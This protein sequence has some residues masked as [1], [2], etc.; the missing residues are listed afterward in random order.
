MKKPCA[1]SANARELLPSLYDNL[2]AAWLEPIHAEDC[3]APKRVRPVHILTKAEIAEATHRDIIIEERVGEPELIRAANGLPLQLRFAHADRE[4]A[5]ALIAE[6]V[7]DGG[8]AVG[9]ASSAKLMTFAERVAQTDASVL[10]QG[11]TGTG[12]EG[13]ARFIHAQSPRADKP[14]IAVN[15]AAMP[16]T[17]VEAILFG[18]KRGAFT[19]ASTEA[20]GLFRAADGGSL[21]LDEITELPLPLQAKLLRALQEGEVLPVGETRPV[22]VNVRII[23]AANRDFEAE[24]AEGRF[25]EDLYWRLNVV[26]IALQKLCERRQDIPAITAAMLLHLQKDDARFAWPTVNAL[27]ALEAH[28]FP[29]NARELNNMLQRALIMREGDRIRAD[30]L[31]LKAPLPQPAS[32]KPEP[33][34]EGGKRIVHGRDLQSLSRAVEFDAIRSA[35]ESNQGNRRATAKMLGISER[36][37]RYRLADMRELEAAA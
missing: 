36:T 30:D 12:K 1:I 33:I 18:H 25:R 5:Q 23:A 13:V 4:F 29:G 28:D 6:A 16:E 3:D 7:R 14:F 24:V 11:E 35:L 15:C 8:P 22:I 20:E 34:P 10:V 26:P 17:M 37:L 19:G 32:P 21:F 9:E 2:R 27:K 31:Q